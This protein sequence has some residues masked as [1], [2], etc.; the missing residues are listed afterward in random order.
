MINPPMRS[1]RE[2][3]SGLYHFGRMIDKI[4]LHL[5]GKLPDEYKPNFGLARGLDG[6]LSQ[7]LNLTHTQIVA[8]VSEGGTDAEILEW[9]FANGLRP[10]ETQIQVWNSF[11]E[12][13]GCR[14]RAAATVQRVREQTGRADIATIF[15]C[16]DAN[17]GRLAPTA[18]VREAAKML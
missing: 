11:A 1:P 16:N 6:L 8:L 5:R 18:K 10:N 4:G 3:V 9:C 2:K 15:D 17:E 7:F 14:D 12:K 13:I